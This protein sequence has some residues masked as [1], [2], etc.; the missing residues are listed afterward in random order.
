MNQVLTYVLYAPHLCICRMEFHF[1]HTD[2]CMLNQLSKPF[3]TSH[4]S[5][6]TFDWDS[7]FIKISLSGY[8][9]SSSVFF[10][11]ELGLFIPKQYTGMEEWALESEWVTVAEQKVCEWR[12]E[13]EKNYPVCILWLYNQHLF[14][15][16]LKKGGLQSC[17][18]VCRH[19]LDVITLSVCAGQHC[20]N[21]K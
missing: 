12:M 4:V 3:E 2:I 19:E 18:S 11:I 13:Q 20:T 6:A 16:R 8:S 21:V 14:F 17:W 10:F 7:D 9:P 1:M 5:P 15:P